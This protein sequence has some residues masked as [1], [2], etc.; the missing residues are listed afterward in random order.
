MYVDS[1][2]DPNRQ[3]FE[4]GKLST[5]GKSIINS[6]CDVWLQNIIKCGKYNHVKFVN[7][8]YFRIRP[9]KVLPWPYF[10]MRININLGLLLGCFWT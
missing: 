1:E 10:G 7:L 4:L 3:T 5:A 2:G 9:G 6:N 8:V